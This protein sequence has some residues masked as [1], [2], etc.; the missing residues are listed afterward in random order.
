MAKRIIIKMKNR[1]VLFVHDG[2]LYIDSEGQYYSVH[3]TDK[4]IEQYLKLGDF[5]TIVMRVVKLAKPK[6]KN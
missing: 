2:P 5:V 4:L 1:R 3:F 6:K